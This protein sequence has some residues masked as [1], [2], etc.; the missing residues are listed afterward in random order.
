[1]ADSGNCC[2]A[3]TEF[4][5]VKQFASETQLSTATVYRL[6]SR[7]KLRSV[8]DLR[9]KRIP[10][11]ELKRWQRCDFDAANFRRV[12]ADYGSS[13]PKDRRNQIEKENEQR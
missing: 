1:M 4:L 3:D 6:V 9:H 10:R 8:P 7:G 2:A 12:V 11:S 13:H 5:T